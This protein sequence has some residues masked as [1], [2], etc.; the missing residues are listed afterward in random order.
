MKITKTSRDLV[1]FMAFGDGYL[2]NWGFL[3]FRHCLKQKEYLEWKMKLLNRSGITTTKPYFV[4]NNGFGAYEVRTY[5]HRFIKLYKK[6]IYKRHKNI[7]NRHLLNKLT[8][9]GIAIWY[10]DDGGLAKKKRDGKIYANELM[11]NTHISK[12]DNQI[13]IDYFKEKWG[14]SFRQ[15]TT[16]GQYR[17]CCGTKEARKFIKIVKPYVEQVKCMHHKIDVLPEK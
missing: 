9:L 10:M 16:R 5:S 1:V 8:P 11:I 12:E 15:A 3:S 4:A 13:I 6:I 7:A 17:L 14:I 2:N